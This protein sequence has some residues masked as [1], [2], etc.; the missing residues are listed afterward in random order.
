MTVLPQDGEFITPGGGKEIWDS[1]IP[2]EIYV[3]V[4]TDTKREIRRSVKVPPHGVLR[5]ST[6]DRIL[7]QEACINRS[8]DPFTNG[9][10]IRRD[11]DQQADERTVSP[12]ALTT[13]QLVAL[14]A[15]SGKAF[16]TAVDRLGEIPVR[17]LAE[18]A[19][20]VDASVSQVAHL[21][22]SIKTR[23]PLGGDMPSNAEARRERNS[24]R[25][26]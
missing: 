17:R 3:E 11:A 22:K 5:I 25:T 4:T 24:N 15:K 21:E 23:W 9:M 20:E 26:S 8:V 18:M 1:Q 6:E 2:G 13:E 16:E 14:F 10:L 7:A 19:P 12:D